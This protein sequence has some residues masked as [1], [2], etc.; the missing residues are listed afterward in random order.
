MFDVPS[1]MD[2]AN[3]GRL[4]DWVDRYLSA[5]AWANAGLREGLRRQ[6]RYW[7]GPLTLALDRMER[8]CGPEPGMEFPVPMDAWQR[9]VSDMAARLADPAAIPPLILEW[10]AGVLS[11]RDGNHRHA[12]MPAA[13]WS[14]CWVIVWCNSASD[15]HTAWE[16]LGASLPSP[17]IR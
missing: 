10:R 8:C 1:C 12:A 13:G 9:R 7:I 15:V 2:A 3:C 17:D 11:V 5:G 6:R 14:S 16:A 4:D